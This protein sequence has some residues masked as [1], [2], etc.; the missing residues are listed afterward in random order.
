MSAPASFS[1]ADEAMD[2]VRAGLGYLTQADAAS[3]PGVTQ[4]RLLR[5]LERAES[6][7]TAARARILY[8]FS[9]QHAYEADG[10]FGPRPWLV[11]QT[12]VSAKA[13]SGA[14]GWMHRLAFH[15]YVAEALAAGKLSASYARQICAWS[16]LLP[17]SHR[18]AADQIL[19]D[20]A[21]G[22]VD[23]ADLSRLAEEMFTRVAPP[24]R[25]EDR[26]FADRFF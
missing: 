19:V 15:T 18:D 23:L 20:A 9:A 17:V 5:E 11:S 22:G 4:A 7:H 21:V 14:V 3:M 8:A 1:S 12:R 25:D 2:M 6:Q 26:G 16:R 13:A 24:D 10:Q